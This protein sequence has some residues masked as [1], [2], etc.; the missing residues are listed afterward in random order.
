[1]K[2]KPLPSDNVVPTAEGYD[3]WAKV[4]ESDGN[5]LTHLEEPVLDRLLGEVAGRRILDI[6]CG[7]GRH[8]LRLAARGAEV[9]ALDF[10][11]G[12]LEQAKD[13][14]G[15]DAVRW[16]EHDL[17]LP[18]PLD[19]HAFDRVLSCLVVEHIADLRL[20]FREM[21]RVCAADGEVV[22]TA[23]HPAMMLIGKQ[24]SFRDP[25]SGEKIYP[26]SHRHQVSDFVNAAVDS[27]LVLREMSEGAV[28]EA[29]AQKLPRAAKYLGW[30]MLLSLRFTLDHNLVTK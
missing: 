16:V 18:L 2:A 5:P 15:A 17:R 6:G 12:M 21:A 19:D 30:L 14:R 26:E 13:K 8:A 11:R 7:T 29:L 22:V 25:D 28:D 4:Y 10:S 3:R 20:L 23:M 27:G 9:T 1:M 24:A